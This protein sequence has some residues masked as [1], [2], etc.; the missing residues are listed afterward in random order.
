MNSDLIGP[1]L[2]SVAPEPRPRF[3]VRKQ[4][5][6]LWT[7]LNSSHP[8]KK[9]KKTTTLTDLSNSESSANITPEIGYRLLLNLLP[10]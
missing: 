3:S 5:S 8:G 1:D 10:K 2:F 6:P 9:G 7:K 4:I